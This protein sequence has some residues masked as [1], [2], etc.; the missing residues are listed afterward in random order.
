MNR[1]VTFFKDFHGTCE[2]PLSYWKTMEEVPMEIQNYFHKILSSFVIYQEEKQEFVCVK[3]L[4]P[5]DSSGFCPRCQRTVFLPQCLSEKRCLHRTSLFLDDPFNV[6][7]YAFS[8]VEAHPILYQ[9]EANIRYYHERISLPF[10]TAKF[11]LTHAYD[12]RKNLM[13]DLLQ[14]KEFSFSQLEEDIQKDD[15]YNPIFDTEG[16][17][18]FLYLDNLDEL[19]KTQV[20]RYSHLWDLKKY[21][22]EEP[23]S[24]ASLSFFPIYF[25]QFEYLVK[26]GLCRLALTN[27]GAVKK[28]SCFRESFGIDKKYY[29][30]MKKIDLSYSQ[31]LALRTYPTTD[32]AMLS[33]VEENQYEIHSLKEFVSIE[34][35]KNYIEEEEERNVSDYSDYIESALKLGLDLTNKQ[36]LFPKNFKEAHDEVTTEV[37]LNEHPLVNQQIRTI[38]QVLSLNSYE[39][40][41]YVI[42]PADSVSSLVDEG[43]QMSNCVRLYSEKMSKNQC[44]I[45]FMRKKD[46]KEK[47]LVTVEVRNGKVVQARTRFNGPIDASMRAFLKRWQEKSLPIV[48]EED[49]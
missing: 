16:S 17:P 42:F 28:S 9:F 11:F 48:K 35:V 45:Y 27:P 18:C 40:D 22:E 29:S 32:F 7:F 39:E 6:I 38:S 12:L 1:Q 20:Y 44:Q 3:C 19:K 2:K 5:L 34:K 21:F 25:P 4:K 47:S 26:M 24:C 36:I 31:L 46:A 33:F 43:N 14:E 23:F 49:E 10:G 15:F 8:L 37:I 41:P 13:F 30:F